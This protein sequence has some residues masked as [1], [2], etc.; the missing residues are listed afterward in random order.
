[1]YVLQDRCAL[2]Q[3]DV[4]A[5]ALN[6]RTI[7]MTTSVDLASIP[8]F[9]KASRLYAS[10]NVE[11]EGSIEVP[12]HCY[13]DSEEISSTE[14]FDRL[15]ST[16]RYWQVD[17]LP[18][19][20]LTFCMRSNE[21]CE[22]CHIMQI[23]ENEVPH[24]KELR[25]LVEK[26]NLLSGQA[27]VFAA[28]I[29]LLECLVFMQ[30]NGYPLT[31]AACDVAALHGHLNCL[32]FLIDHGV[33][34]SSCCFSAAK[35]GHLDVIHYLRCIVSPWDEK[36]SA[37][38]AQ[39]GHLECLTYALE[40]GCP[41]ERTQIIDVAAK[42][43]QFECLEYLH[44]EVGCPITATTC[45]AAATGGYLNILLYAHQAGATW[46][47][48]A[49]QAAA[50]GGHL[51]CL[52]FLHQSG[53]LWDWHT[54]EAAAFRGHL[55]CLEYAHERGCAWT[56]AATISAARN[57]QLAVLQYALAHNCPVSTLALTA[58]CRFGHVDCVALLH[59]AGLPLTPSDC[60]AAL[61]NSHLPVLR[62]LHE[63]GCAWGVYKPGERSV[64]VR[65]NAEVLECMRYAHD[66]GCAW[67]ARFVERAAHLGC[68]ETLQYAH[69]GGCPWDK[70]ACQT[71]LVFKNFDCLKYLI[72]QGCPV[73]PET[74]ALARDNPS[75]PCS[76]YLLD[77]WARQTPAAETPAPSVGT[78]IWDT[79]KDLVHSAMAQN[80]KQT[81]VRGHFI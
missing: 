36:V 48:S 60:D 55:S 69:R 28:S 70:R 49:C 79:L 11:E 4:S 37:V 73:G 25:G 81:T 65:N 12:V 29:G 26:D 5:T 19:F 75:E 18:A 23:Y 38:C 42:S 16:L 9:L 32:K 68:L 51:H 80:R 21:H 10:L 71:A 72:E 41:R 46:N 15:L 74:I 33:T 3:V 22:I 61:C 59:E 76:A 58:A 77:C 6:R 30:E 62:Y 1:V 44:R 54:C 66:H 56:D 43:G 27:G 17:T 64:G 52:T 13:I 45:A 14:D 2:D 57:G 34:S 31:T 40:N 63:H 20:V 67:D 39:M 7:V 47:A 53:C 8:S 50:A 35:G 78:S 24:V